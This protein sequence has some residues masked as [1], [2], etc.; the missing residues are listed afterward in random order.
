M[1]HVKH[2]WEP[3]DPVHSH[4]HTP[5]WVPSLEGLAASWSATATVEPVNHS[6]LRQ[7]M[8]WWAAAAEPSPWRWLSG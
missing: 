3:G 1:F 5:A 6:V 8:V 7:P 4:D 2:R